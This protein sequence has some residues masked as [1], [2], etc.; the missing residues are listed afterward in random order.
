[1]SQVSG[2]QSIG[3][4][5]QAYLKKNTII[6]VVKV[7]GAGFGS[8]SFSFKFNIFEQ[9]CNRSWLE[10]KFRT[11]QNGSILSQYGCIIE[12]AKLTTEDE[13]QYSGRI[14]VRAQDTGNQHIGVQHAPDQILPLAAL[15]SA[16]ITSAGIEATP[17]L[18]EAICS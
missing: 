7:L 16:S 10:S 15:I 3:F 13:R 18:L 12:R 1:M 17:D 11:S 4:T 6:L 14:A 5:A 9:C 8:N 2:D